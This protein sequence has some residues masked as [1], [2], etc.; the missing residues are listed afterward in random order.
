[1]SEDGSVVAAD[2]RGAGAVGCCA[3]E[4]FEN[5]GFDGV[6]AVIDAGGHD[7]DGEGVF[8]RWVEAELSRGAEEERAD[9]HCCAGFVGRDEFGVE[10]DGE[11]DTVEEVLFWDLWDG[12]EIGGALHAESVLVGAEDG[13]GTVWLAEGFH[14]FVALDSVVEAGGHA[15]DGEMGGGDEARW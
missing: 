15:V 2:F 8:V 5:Q 6:H 9:V 3:V 7:E 11:V 12:D 1:M 4:V 13:D 14:A 10:R